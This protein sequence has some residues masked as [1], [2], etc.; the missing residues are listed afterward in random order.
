MTVNRTGYGV[1]RELTE[2][3]ERTRK[4]CDE[5]SIVVVGPYY[6]QILCNRDVIYAEAVGNTYLTGRARLTRAQET[7]LTALGWASP[8]VPCHPECPRPH[9]NFH[10]AWPQTV[11][12]RAMARELLTTIVAIY[13]RGEGDGVT[14]LGG[15]RQHPASTGP[16]PA[17]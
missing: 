15:P 8:D 9:P 6:V 17:H 2:T 1:E 14:F 5:Y 11:A 13:M 3:I 16:V 7:A 10:R 4:T 12:S